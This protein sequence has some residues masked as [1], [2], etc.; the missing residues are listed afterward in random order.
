MPSG[1]GVIL[2][3]RSGSHS[4]AAAALQAHWPDAFAEWVASGC[5]GHPA[6]FLPCDENFCGQ[7]D[8]AIVVRNPVERFRSM[9]AH[10]P[11]RT[12]EE[13]LASPV[14]G[15]LPQGKFSR[16]F[17]FESG[18]DAVAEYL[19]LPLPMIHL[20][21]TDEAKK[22]TLTVAQQSRVRDMYAMDI[23]LWESI[24]GA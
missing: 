5:E 18:L 17:L 11:E 24:G 8:L 6:A 21:A 20:D 19:A 1:V 16:T 9:C 3:P 10:R 15:P 23:A 12:V 2:T 13:H 7:E 14:Y 4:L 22:P